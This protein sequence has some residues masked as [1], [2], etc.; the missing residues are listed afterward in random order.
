[1]QKESCSSLSAFIL[2]SAFSIL[3]LLQSMT[4]KR[5]GI[6]FLSLILVFSMKSSA[7]TGAPRK[8]SRSNQHETQK[9]GRANTQPKLE[10]SKDI[11]QQLAKWQV[12]KMPFT[13]A[14]LT[15]RERQLAEK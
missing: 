1:M 11:D 12:Q 8:K 14:G 3:Q 2:R 13:G 7:Q 5:L 4:M 10:V 15:A 6:A 9:Y